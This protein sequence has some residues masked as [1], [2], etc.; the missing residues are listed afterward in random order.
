MTRAFC[1]P[2]VYS[3]RPFTGP[4]SLHVA[5]EPGGPPTAP[6]GWAGEETGLPGAGIPA[7]NHDDIDRGPSEREQR[8][9]GGA[10]R[11]SDAR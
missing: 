8:Q 3:A 6:P 7:V 9:S 4:N 5:R 10:L 11:P 1:E 2:V